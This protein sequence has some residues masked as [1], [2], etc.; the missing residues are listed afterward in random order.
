V[1]W[2]F[3]IGF[4]LLAQ[5]PYIYVDAAWSNEPV[6]APDGIEELVASENAIGTRGQVIE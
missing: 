3:R 1:K 4:D 2:I 5:A 6:R